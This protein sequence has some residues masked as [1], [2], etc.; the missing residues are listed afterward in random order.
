MRVLL[1]LTILTGIS[2]T[3]TAQ[4][5]RNESR[6][7]SPY[8]NDYQRV[9]A[10]E[11]YTIEIRNGQLWSVG[12]NS[13][14][15]CGLGTW[16]ASVTS[17]TQIGTDNDWVSVS[18]GKYHVI[19]LK[20]NGTIWSWGSNNFYGELGDGTFSGS[21]AKASPHQIGTDN[22]WISISA[23]RDF[24][25]AIKSNG[26]L[27]GWGQNGF[28]QL[29]LGTTTDMNVPTQI[30]GAGNNWKSV[31]AGSEQTLAIKAD[32]K[33][34]A[35]GHNATGCLGIGSTTDQPTPIQ[36]G[37]DRTWIKICSGSAY[38]L[39]LKANGEIWGWGANTSGQIGDGSTTQ[40]LS[41]VLVGTGYTHINCKGTSSLALKEGK[42][43]SWGA[44][45]VGQLGDG[46]TT[47]HST[48]AQV[49]TATNYV[50]IE[51]GV[52]HSLAVLSTG[53]LTAT[54]HN[55]YYQLGLGTTT[56]QT[57]FITTSITAD[58]WLQV[59]PVGYS[60]AAIKLDGTLWVWGDNSDGRFGNGTTVGSNVPVQS[61]TDNT[62]IAMAA[63]SGG[64]NFV[65]LKADGS[66][67]R[68]ANSSTYP[69]QVVVT[70]KS[71]RSVAAGLGH[72]LAVATDGTLWTWGNNTY[73]QLGQGSTTSSSTPIQVGTATNWMC[74][75]GSW[76]NSTALKS[77]GTL[78]SCGRST[79]GQLGNG[80]S[81]QST[82][83]VQIGSTSDYITVKLMF[84]SG[85]TLKVNGTMYGWGRNNW[86]QLCDGTT[87]HRLSPIQ[88]NTY[89]K[90]IS[91][92]AAWEGNVKALQSDGSLWG[93][94]IG[95][96]GGTVTNTSS[97]VVISG[98]TNVIQA[99]VSNY[100]TA[101]I[102][103]D[104]SAMCV[105]GGNSHGE[106]GIGSSALN[107][108][109]WDC[110]DLTALDIL[111]NQSAETSKDPILAI[112]E[113]YRSPLIVS[114]N[115]ATDI[116]TLH[117]SESSL[118]GQFTLMSANGIIA[119]KGGIV[120]GSSFQLDMSEFDNGIY[121]L[122]YF[123]GVQRFTTRIVKQ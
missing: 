90:W 76:G 37:T 11:H 83:F 101:L 85:V 6:F 73:G 17:F 77:D 69:T 38:T 46:T 102:K 32:G 42:L 74:A 22:D 116:I 71:W 4:Y 43:Y 59:V 94:G 18:C 117:L 19:A 12:R 91:L 36:V 58:G 7:S 118:K 51:A 82:S 111:H 100:H 84:D 50:S 78:W 39:G 52:F 10:G 92:S 57:S 26:T 62:W 67:W 106:L 123:D 96:F 27:Y 45:T 23:G 86:Y 80:T 53:V 66:M 13:A 30:T 24:S 93:W 119:H 104:R 79:F 3:T 1:F 89:T 55:G 103:S 121:L 5:S 112:D 60:T 97:P 33:L 68:F 65:G 115:P 41:P 75:A 114:P 110:G 61:G 9:G 108:N 20:S 48:P 113:N 88:I 40:R 87:T 34:Y 70:G 98:Q 54:G 56:T 120:S 109:V 47:G 44:N 15:Q 63:F 81:V 95:G 64:G 105:T 25:M 8:S 49:G 99:E 28:Y 122:E 31:T 16:T 21:V 2:F 72:F 35:W 107:V 29:G 14:G